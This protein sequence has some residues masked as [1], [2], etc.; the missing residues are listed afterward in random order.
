MR[1]L[2]HRSAKQLR[3]LIQRERW[4]LVRFLSLSVTPGLSDDPFLV[5]RYVMRR[6]PQSVAVWFFP[7]NSPS[8]PLDVRLGLPVLDESGWGTP[9]AV[10]PTAQ[11]CTLEGEGGVLGPHNMVF[12][13]T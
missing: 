13:L 12:D 7:R 5:R 2:V 1:R 10:F 4:R 9:D 3:A 6:S 11:G 8:V